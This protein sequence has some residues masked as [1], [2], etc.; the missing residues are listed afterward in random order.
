ML[1]CIAI[2]RCMDKKPYGNTLNNPAFSKLIDK[3]SSDQE[4]GVIMKTFDKSN[5]PMNKFLERS[6]GSVD[7][8][9]CEGSTVATLSN[10]ERPSTKPRA[11]STFYC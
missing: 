1:N 4:G 2:C 6:V 7:Q 5:S 8:S 9:M 10:I 11:I 3:V